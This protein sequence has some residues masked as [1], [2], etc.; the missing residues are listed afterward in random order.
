MTAIMLNREYSLGS[1]FGLEHTLLG[2]AWLG[3]TILWAAFGIAVRF[4]LHQPPVTAAL[5][6]LAGAVLHFASEVWHQLGHA[7]AARRVGAPM[8]GVR[9]WWVL[10]ASVYPADE[11][12]QP[13]GVHLRRALG[14]PASSLAL[15][16]ALGVFLLALRPGTPLFHLAAFACL[17]NLLVFGLGSFLPLGFTDGSTILR[18]VGK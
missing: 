10:G 17:E 12:E 13:P 8:Q 16:A 1:F 9:Y 18:Y 15:S 7:W 6:G 3:F 14:G 5:L 11:P 4:L 2:S